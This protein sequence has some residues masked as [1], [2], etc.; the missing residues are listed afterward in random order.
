MNFCSYFVGTMSAIT[1]AEA[2]M[3]RTP[4]IHRPHADGVIVRPAFSSQSQSSF[5]AS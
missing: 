4:E 1:S 2:S 5:L 3:L